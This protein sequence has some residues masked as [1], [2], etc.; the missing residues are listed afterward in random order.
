MGTQH[1]SVTLGR[2][3]HSKTNGSKGREQTLEAGQNQELMRQQ[4]LPEPPHGKETELEETADL[5][6]HPTLSWSD[7]AGSQR[8]RETGT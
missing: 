3:Y 8:A 1:R 2:D 5:S 4:P 7:S 6:S